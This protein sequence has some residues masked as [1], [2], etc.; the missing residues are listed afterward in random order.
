MEIAIAEAHNAAIAQEVPV[1]AVLVKDNEIIAKAGNRVCRDSDPSAHA[2]ILVLREG[3]RI[4]GSEQIPEC[5]LYTTLEPCTM[6]A[7]AISLA[8]IRRLYFGAH[9]PKRGGIFWFNHPTCHHRP[10][11]YGG[12][13]ETESAKLLRDFFV[14]KR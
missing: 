14:E 2:E 9:D 3:C 4:L 6:C 13:A 8:R 7:T 1:G 12:I 10:E 5:D 11:I